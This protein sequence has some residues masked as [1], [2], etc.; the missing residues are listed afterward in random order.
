MQREIGHGMVV[1]GLSH[2]LKGTDISTKIIGMGKM[3]EAMALANR[4]KVESLRS[5]ERENRRVG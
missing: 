3:L 4:K 2:Y 1:I 5:A